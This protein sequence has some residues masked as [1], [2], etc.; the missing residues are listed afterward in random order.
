[1]GSLQQHEGIRQAGFSLIEVMITVFIFGILAGIA[2]PGMQDLIANNRAQTMTQGLRTA[3]ALA[4]S[5]AIRL[6]GNVSVCGSN[7]ASTACS[8]STNWSGGWLVVADAS[9]EVLRSWEAS[10]G[11]PSVTSAAAR[12]QF[13]AL[14]TPGAATN[15]A[16][17]ISGQ[18]RCVRVLV[19][20][21]SHSE[22]GGC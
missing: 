8:G 17:S 2:V 4:Q 10:A 1:M 19:S 18:A 14:G 6:R 9:G 12:V 5:E 22:K 16:V 15:I 20:G 11:G 21:Q 3:T 7:A 13:D